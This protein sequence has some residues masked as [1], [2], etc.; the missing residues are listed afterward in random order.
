LPVDLGLVAVDHHLDPLRQIGLDLGKDAPGGVGDADRRLVADAVDVQA[1][2][3]LAVVGADAVAVGE[4]VAYRG[5]V[6]KS[7]DRAA[8][9]GDDRDVGELPR[10]SLRS[11]TRNRIS[12]A[13]VLTLPPGTSM[14]VRA[15]LVPTSSRVSP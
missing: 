13:D 4:I 12:P 6:G 11:L 2:G 8:G 10:Q 15:I 9:R 1:D 3:L 5:D 7:Q 14:A